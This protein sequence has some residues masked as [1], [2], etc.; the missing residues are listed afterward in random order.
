MILL[1]PRPY[2]LGKKSQQLFQKTSTNLSPCAIQQ[3]QIEILESRKI[4]ESH[5]SDSELSL[6]T[7]SA[8]STQSSDYA[9][10]IIS[11]ASTSNFYLS[12][13]LYLIFYRLLKI[14]QEGRSAQK[15]SR[16]AC[17][18]WSRS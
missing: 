13:E 16:R 2:Q 12:I 10:S 11:D 17:W 14:Y 5:L 6:R 7:E 3:N 18:A 1:A 4:E 15:T 8:P 9:D